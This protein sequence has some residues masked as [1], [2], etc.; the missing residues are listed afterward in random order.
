MKRNTPPHMKLT[1]PD[2]SRLTAVAFSQ[3]KYSGI[4]LYL[5]KQRG[6]G[7][8]I[9][10]AEY[11]TERDGQVWIRA[12]CSDEADTAYYQPYGAESSRE[13]SGWTQD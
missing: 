4:S 3:E 7:V 5:Q 12:Y 6:P 11:N 8:V 10:F 13:G 9:W 2:G 1:L